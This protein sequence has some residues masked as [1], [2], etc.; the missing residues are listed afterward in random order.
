MK[1]DK[2]KIRNAY[3][4]GDINWL[5]EIYE[6]VIGQTKDDKY[7]EAINLI[8]VLYRMNCIKIETEI[9]RYASKYNEKVQDLYSEMKIDLTQYIGYEEMWEEL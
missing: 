9:E 7:Y 2:E 5:D 4:Y 6:Q 3:G 1:L 8:S